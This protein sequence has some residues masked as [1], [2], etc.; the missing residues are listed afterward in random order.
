MTFIGK[1]ACNCVSGCRF[2]VQFFTSNGSLIM[3]G[4]QFEFNDLI[5]LYTKND[6]ER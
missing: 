6:F 2:T 1:K 4:I 3:D 5:S